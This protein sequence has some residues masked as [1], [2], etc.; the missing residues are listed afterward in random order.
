MNKYLSLFF[1]SLMTYSFTSFAE[2]DVNKTVVADFSENLLVIPCVRVE[3][4]PFDGYYNVVMEISGN[5]D[6]ADWK[7][8]HVT[9]AS[10][11]DCHDDSSED[12]TLDEL[13]ESIGMPPLA[14]LMKPKPYDESNDDSDEDEDS[15]DLD[16]QET[17]DDSVESTGEIVIQ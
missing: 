14:E 4:S 12:A 13:L 3:A 2:D 9:L 8:L 5:G 10:E 17:D 16:D 6:G 1:A 15:D 7:V 11:E